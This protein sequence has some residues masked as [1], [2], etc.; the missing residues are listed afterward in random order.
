MQLLVYLLLLEINLNF[1]MMMKV[2]TNFEADSMY[3]FHPSHYLPMCS[4]QSPTTITQ[5]SARVSG[6][7]MKLKRFM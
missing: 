2:V 7:F 4:L 1:C 6:P 3:P 5:F